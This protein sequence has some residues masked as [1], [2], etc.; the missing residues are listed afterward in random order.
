MGREQRL[1]FIRGI[2]SQRNSR[3]LVYVTGDRRGLETKIAPDTFP[4]LL[5]HLS[6][7]GH[8]KQIDLYLYSS[9]GIVMAGYAMVNL[10]REFCDYLGVIVPFKAWSCATLVA[11]GADEIVMSRM[12]QLSPIDTSIESPLNPRHPGSAEPVPV[13]VEDVVSYIEF[14]RR[15][16]D[17]KDEESL[18]RVFDRL[19]QSV[20]PLT[21]GS[22]G[23][24]Q[25]ET[26]FL[27]KALLAYHIKDSK[28]I[29]EIVDILTRGR[30]SHDY[31]VG[32]RE[33][34]EV[35]GLPVVDVASTLETA[36]VDLYKEYDK[37]LEISMPYHPEAVLGQ[38]ETAV[39]T[40][41]RA[42]IESRDITHVFRTRKEVKRV[43]MGPPQVPVLSVAYSERILSEG[44]LE[45]NSL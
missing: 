31:L 45:D 3:L 25:K 15:E 5:D 17:I 12:G 7:M 43:S 24:S 36:V 27:A 20:H 16:L 42:V 34:K 40:F 21:I 33:A 22:V 8:Q 19:S 11:L 10:V 1:R 37:L 18:V 2:E 44:W 38:E 39:G 30:F 35:L 14:A 13:S 4:F 29:D 6:H 23:R 9:G 32:R 28:K 41:N 26:S